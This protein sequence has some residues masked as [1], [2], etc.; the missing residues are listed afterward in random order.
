M[1]LFFSDV[2]R[3]GGL[4]FA[5]YSCHLLVNLFVYMFTFIDIRQRRLCTM[6]FYHHSFHCC[7]CCRS[8]CSVKIRPCLIRCCSFMSCLRLT[9]K[10]EREKIA[11]VETKQCHAVNYEC[12]CN[13]RSFCTYHPIPH[14]HTHHFELLVG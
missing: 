13:A 4:L 1:V 5:I 11:K 2:L 6:K 12:I 8:R 7:C 3:E 9:M 10:R 14:T